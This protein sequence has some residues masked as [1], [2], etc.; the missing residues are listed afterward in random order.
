MSLTTHAKSSTLLGVKAVQV[1]RDRIAYSDEIFAE[2]V[3][4]RLAA[5]SQGSKHFYKYRLA[6]VV[7]GECV[8]RY[9]NESGKG[10]HRHFRGEEFKYSFRSIEQL[11]VDFHNEVRRMNHED[12]RA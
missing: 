3:V 5:P 2:V 4:W 10:D 11:L 1:V 8:L 6:Y 12:G 7:S 9:D